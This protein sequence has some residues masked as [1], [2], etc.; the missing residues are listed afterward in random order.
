LKKKRKINHSLLVIYTISFVLFVLTSQA[1][2]VVHDSASIKQLQAVQVSASRIT[3]SYTGKHILKFDS[4]ILQAYQF[5]TLADLLGSNSGVFIKNYGHGGLAT[6]SLRGGNASQTALLWNGFNINH[7]MLGQ[8]DYS[9]LPVFLFDE[10]QVEHGGSSSLNGSGA[11]NGSIHLNTLMGF[12]S[13]LKTG[14]SIL[15]GSFQ[16]KKIAG[17]V[18]YGTQKFYSHTKI[19][20]HQSLNNFLF[21]NDSLQTERRKHSAY[22]TNG[23]M[24]DFGWQVT[25]T[26]KLNLS[27]WYNQFERQLPKVLR[28]RVESKAFQ[29]DE[30]IRVSGSWKNYGKQYSLM[31][32]SAWFQDVLNYTDELA[33]I[34]SKSKVQTST[35][36]VE[37]NLHLSPNIDVLS[38][39]QFMYQGVESNNYKTIH[40]VSKAS[41]LNGIQFHTLTKK[42]LA[43]ITV[44]QEQ[45]SIIHIPATA[46]VALEA[47]PI[48][49]LVLKLNGAKVYRVPTLND[50]Y[51]NPGGN[52]QLKPEHG[53]TADGTVD[54]TIHF[55]KLQINWGGTIFYKSINDWILWLPANNGIS[56]PKNVLQVVSK[57]AETQTD[58][59]YVF[60]KFYIK[61]GIQTNYVLSTVA[62]SN[63]IDDASQNKQLIYTPRYNF[64]GN[65]SFGTKKWF[66]LYTQQYVGYRF[67]SSDNSS[68]LIPYT[69]GTLKANYKLTHKKMSYTFQVSI[70]NSWNTSYVVL[71]NQPMPLR[72]YEIGISIQHLYKLKHK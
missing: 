63:L 72:Y 70:N 31:V 50:W 13:T 43:H 52:P 41:L 61:T 64:N 21:L 68:W 30:N 40:A 57:G 44:R 48:N 16:S 62:K 36:E 55:K 3:W 54:A 19:Y 37:V 26:N 8:S 69:V 4:T 20:R 25:P 49:G 67:T 51:W 9:Q 17:Y 59:K 14:I 23:I 7:P 32:R 58:I 11:V 10:L 18:K 56:S 35:S 45:S 27:V 24:Q 60:D 53:Y 39:F 47:K 29:Y 34:F 42:Y 71:L 33:A 22:E 5:Q 1:Q 15:G 12:D 28:T 38:G 46:Q 2:H 65:L 66:V 6:T